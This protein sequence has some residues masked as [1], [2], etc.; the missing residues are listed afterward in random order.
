MTMTSIGDLA[1]SLV[2]R[3]R[4]AD[5][6]RA[7]A[8]LTSEL[9]SGRIS[10]IAGRLAGDLTH[11]TDIDR[12]LGRL[13][14]YAVAA[15]EA[16]LLAGSAQAG[17]TRLHDLGTGLGTDLLDIAP[18][19]PAVTRT[20]AAAR[21]RGDLADAIAALNLRGG[22]RSVFGGAAT[23]RPPLGTADTLLAGLKSAIAGA[24][25]VA[26]IRQ[27]AQDWFDDPGGFRAALYQGSDQALAPIRIGRGET[28]S[29]TLRA[30]DPVFRDLLRETALAALA[31][32]PDL[33]LD[34]TAEAALLRGA[35][36]GLLTAGN[37]LTGLGADLGRAEARIDETATRN[38]AARAG[39]DLAR[40][41][42]LAADPYDTATRL[43]EV[44]FQLESLYAVTARSS[45]LSLLS[46]LP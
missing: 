21:A 3:A 30:D 20:H 42:V 18:T 6:K 43:Q 5:L 38:A 19:S 4:A 9:A 29:L 24:D 40:N 37:R 1:Q 13:D 34:A 31:T 17:V 22:G 33:G 32:D 25:T 15:R 14:G 28:V 16:A 44:Q 36:E 7:T 23:D 12:N 8:I 35:G 2:L 39:L 26:G 45:R 10:D 41:E 27:A 46:F 11:L